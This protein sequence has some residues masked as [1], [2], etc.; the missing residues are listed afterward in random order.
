M[1]SEP[2]NNKVYESKT[3]Y[4][5]RFV[6]EFLLS[7]IPSGRLVLDVGCST[8][9]LGEKLIKEKQCQVY[10]IDISER[11]VEHAKK[12]LTDAAWLDIE[13]EMFPFQ[14]LRFDVIIMADILEHLV[15][16][17]TALLKTKKYLKD[18]GFILISLPNVANLRIRLRLLFGQWDYQES[19]ILDDTHL[20]FYTRKTAQQMFERAGFRI[21]NI[22]AT[23]GFDFLIGKMGWARRITDQLCKLYPK[24]F[25]NQFIFIL[26]SRL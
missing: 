4:Y 13:T 17:E 7:F 6:N 18:D 16:P 15:H 26:R 22:S 8:G 12:R 23:P 21:C 9:R 11:A 20:R 1:M 25:A 24:L 10:G 5:D 2:H 14:N 3:E 19:G